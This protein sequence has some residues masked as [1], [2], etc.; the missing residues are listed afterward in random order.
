MEWIRAYVRLEVE[1]S[2][3][4]V[5][6]WRRA[7]D[8]SGIPS[9][10][11]FESAVFNPGEFRTLIPHAAFREMTDRDAYWGAKIV[12]S[13]SDAQIAAAVEAVQYEDP[14]A[15]DFLVNTLIERRDKTASY[16]FDRVAPLDF[17]SVRE[18]ALHFHDLA[19]DIGLEAPRNYEVELEPADGSSSA[20]RRIPLDQARLPLDELDAD[21]ATRFSLKIKVAGN[22][23]RPACVELTRKGLQWTVTRVRHG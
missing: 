13:F 7:A 14:R 21:G 20:T 11:N 17:F 22:P 15:R 9:V 2:P 8:N 3:I 12:A 16:W 19:V 1:L 4:I 23:A 5:E 18:G 10:G 6:P